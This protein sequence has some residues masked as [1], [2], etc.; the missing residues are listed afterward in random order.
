MS[1]IAKNSGYKKPIIGNWI[2]R[3]GKW[4]IEYSVEESFLKVY[5]DLKSRAS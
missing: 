1:K 5:E 4:V 3:G 2:V